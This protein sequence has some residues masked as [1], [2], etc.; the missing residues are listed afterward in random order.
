MIHACPDRLWYVREILL[1]ELERQGA[2]VSVWT[3]R[4]RKGN[5]VSCMEAFATCAGDGD[6]WHLQDDVLPAR[7]FADRAMELEGVNGIICGFVNEV[8]GPDCNL[9]GN[10]IPADMWYSFPCIRI[11]NELARECAQ[12][13]LGGAWKN[14]AQ[15]IGEALFGSGRG[16]DWFFK[17]F[18]EICHP[19]DPV[20]NLTPCLV[21]HVDWLIGGSMV[22]AWRGFCAR[23]VYWDDEE[24]V[25]DLKQR[26]K[27][28]GR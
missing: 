25:E 12:W 5:L 17:E 13:F 14:E 16:D 2:D 4:E 9:R 23:A 1:P 28:L 10:V 15:A 3:D 18:M 27:A 20:L 19:V 7:D 6:T 24:L 11:P 8:G 21:E 22:S 26:I